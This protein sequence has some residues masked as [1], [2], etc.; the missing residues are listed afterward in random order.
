MIVGIEGDEQGPFLACLECLGPLRVIVE[1]VKSRALP[2]GHHQGSR[3]AR[4]RGPDAANFNRRIP[5]IVHHEAG[6]YVPAE[7]MHRTEVMGMR[8]HLER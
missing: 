1:H 3:R 7:P 5:L 2:L 8:A 4:S 6:V